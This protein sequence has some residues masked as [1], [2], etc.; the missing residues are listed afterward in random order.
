MIWSEAGNVVVE[1]RADADALSRVESA[2]VD[3]VALEV[4]VGTEVYTAINSSFSDSV[5]GR[6]AC[7]KLNEGCDFAVPAELSS[8]P[9]ERPEQLAEP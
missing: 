5:V 6:I 1:I 2:N 4:G 8:S 9:R 7:V 3:A